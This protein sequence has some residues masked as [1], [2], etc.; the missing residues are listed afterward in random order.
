MP[1]SYPGR[2]ANAKVVT[3]FVHELDPEFASARGFA[4]VSGEQ[5]RQRH[6]RM[7]RGELPDYQRVPAASMHVELPVEGLGSISRYR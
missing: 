6:G 7:S 4:L 3:V 1:D 5:Q 2:R